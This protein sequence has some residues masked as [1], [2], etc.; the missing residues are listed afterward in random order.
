[1]SLERII[2]LKDSLSFRL[3]LWYALIFMISSLL[4]M[5]VFYQRVTTKAMKNTD[6]DI[7][8]E[9]IEF[10]E[11]YKNGGVEGVKQGINLEASSEGPDEVFFRLVSD[12]GGIIASSDMAAWGKIDIS[13]D[14]LA[15]ALAGKDPV[16]E[17]L[18]APDHKYG[19]RSAYRLIG[20]SMV[21]QMGISLENNEKYSHMFR[22]L[23]LRLLLPVFLLAAFAGWFM[24]KKAISGVDEV[25]GI[26]GEI[27]QGAYH[28]RVKLKKRSKELDRLADS[29][30]KMV[31][32]LQALI[33]GMKEVND[34]IAHDLRGP[35][36]RI[37]GTA[38][39]TL[40]AKSSLKD[41]EEM[42]ASTI[43]E[44]DDLITMINT[45]LDIAETEAGVG[46]MLRET[47]DVSM[48]IQDACGLFQSIALDKDIRIS[49]D[50][51]DSLLLTCD[52]SKLQR[53]ISNLLD[54]A[55][56]YTPPGGH[57]GIRVCREGN[58]VS[59][60]FTDTGRGIAQEDLPR[61]FERFYRCDAS[62]TEPGTG[63]G[64]SLV[65]VIAEAFGGFVTVEST[66]GKGS[67]FTVVLPHEAGRIS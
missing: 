56:K 6:Q 32:R 33:Q 25:A 51:P 35:L 44:C 45:M 3:T 59:M 27:S 34:N 29:F 2:S 15:Q 37:R 52:R 62:R 7:A 19:T 46:D 31:D 8:E 18:N 28:K 38:E 5:F 65:K 57:V 47:V 48:L 17:T 36:T 21:L 63:L 55:I 26:A 49:A 66:P 30:N 54:N 10:S 12:K 40:M 22:K 11:V 43:E 64:L 42:A 1:M 41:F 53:L 24:A 39:T 14:L 67:V 60:R 13:K 4:V 23:I 58:A 61:I 16:F 20:P 50:V 9:M